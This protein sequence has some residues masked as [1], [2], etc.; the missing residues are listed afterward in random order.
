MVGFAHAQQLLPLYRRG[1]DAVAHHS[2]VGATRDDGRR[3]G[4]AASAPHRRRVLVVKY[5]RGVTGGEGA[6]YP[7]EEEEEVSFAGRHLFTAQCFR[8]DSSSRWATCTCVTCDASWGRVS[9]ET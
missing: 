3:D 6:G 1:L 4:R 2:P 5:L 8:D 7:R 9:E